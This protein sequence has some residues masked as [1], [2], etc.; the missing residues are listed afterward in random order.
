MSFTL[1]GDIKSVGDG[2]AD[3]VIDALVERGI[4]LESISNVLYEGGS[5]VISVDVDSQSTQKEIERIVSRADFCISLDTERSL[6]ACAVQ[7]PNE[8][9]SD[10][11]SNSGSLSEGLIAAIIVGCIAVAFVVALLWLFVLRRRQRRK[12][13]ESAFYSESTVPMTSNPLSAAIGTVNVVVPADQDSLTYNVLGKIS[14]PSASESRIDVTEEYTQ[15]DT[16][17][18]LYKHCVTDAEDDDSYL[19]LV[20]DDHRHYAIS[21]DPYSVLDEGHRLYGDSSGQIYALLEDSHRLYASPSETSEV[22]GNDSTCIYSIPFE[23]LACEPGLSDA[24][25]SHVGVGQTAV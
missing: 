14:S 12:V 18:Q 19:D 10:S 15:L 2:F 6:L 25:G 7:E 24:K 3:R 21:D 4:S 5:I 8:S 16:E 9:G 1:S 13:E 20:Q 22:H 17:H 11:T 23:D